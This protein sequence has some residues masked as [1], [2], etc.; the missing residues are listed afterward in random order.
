MSA[1]AHRRSTMILFT[2]ASCPEGHSIRLVMA[3]KDISAEIQ[4]VDPDHKPEALRTLNPYAETLTLV[5]RDVVLY[6]AHII[7][8]YLDER[9]PHPPLMPADPVAR[10]CNRLYRRRISKDLYPQLHALETG[11]EKKVA[12]AKRYLRE[13]LTE[14]SPLFSQKNYF[15]SDE[16]SLM[17]CYLLPLLWR[18]PRH[19]IHFS[20]P[21][22][23]AIREYTQRLFSQ[24]NFQNTLDAIEPG[25]RR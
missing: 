6:D 25:T 2:E 12:A 21:H 11:G 14:I 20:S 22:C 13:T 15:M 19:G 23:G 4:W 8:E 18:L 3:E 16:Y 5:D 9:F 24:A 7:M 10:A 17:D 1:L